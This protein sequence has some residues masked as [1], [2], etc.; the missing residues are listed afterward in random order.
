[1]LKRIFT[2][3]IRQYSIK[4]IWLKYNI[5]NLKSNDELITENTKIDY[6]MNRF[7]I[8]SKFDQVNNN[9]SDYKVKDLVHLLK[10]NKFD[11][12]LIEVNKITSKIL[13]S[14]LWYINFIFNNKYLPNN[15]NIK[16]KMEDIEHNLNSILHLLGHEKSKPLNKDDNEMI[17]E[18]VK[19]N[20]SNAL[21]WHYKQILNSINYVSL[22][23]N[24][25]NN[26]YLPW[27]YLLKSINNKFMITTKYIITI[28]IIVSLLFIIYV[29]LC[30]CYYLIERD[31]LLTNDVIEFNNVFEELAYN[32]LKHIL[33]KRVKESFVENYLFTLVSD[34]NWKSL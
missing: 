22:N 20:N 25:T 10:T 18:W 31:E 14:P 8:H 15:N 16:D 26:K 24:N 6:I 1:M 13:S 12:K 2:T 11:T 3:N 17:E 19:I 34:T 29:Y 21:N 5:Y 30:E 32:R 9:Y 28:S 4:P 33:D 27:Y 7:N 23:Y